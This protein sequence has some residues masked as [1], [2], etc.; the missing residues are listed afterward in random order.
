MTRKTWG[1]SFWVTRRG[2]MHSAKNMTG[3]RDFY[4][5]V[6][7]SAYLEIQANGIWEGSV[8][9]R[10]GNIYALIED[11]TETDEASG[12]KIRNLKFRKLN[13]SQRRKLLTSVNYNR[14][15]NSYVAYPEVS[16]SS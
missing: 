9:F 4:R 7:S 13:P 5:E 15:G 10:K 6:G 3:E 2:H 16:L 11:E 1:L 12:A 14:K 8:V